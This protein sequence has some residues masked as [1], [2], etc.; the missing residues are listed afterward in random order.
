MCWTLGTP[1]IKSIG[2]FLKLLIWIK[3]FDALK[4]GTGFNSHKKENFKNSFSN[5]VT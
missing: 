2:Y 5:G 1:E 3:L 4:N